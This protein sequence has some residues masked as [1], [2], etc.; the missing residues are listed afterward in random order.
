MSAWKIAVH[1][2]YKNGGT[3]NLR[4]LQMTLG[5]TDIS[6]GSL[7][8]AIRL[9]L[10]VLNGKHSVK[11][12]RPH[13]LFSLTT[14]GKLWCQ[15]KLIDGRGIGTARNGKALGF[16]ATWLLALP[17]GVHVTETR[18]FWQQPCI[19]CGSQRVLYYPDKPATMLCSPCVTASFTVLL[20]R[21]A[22]TVTKNTVSQPH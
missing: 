11:G 3:A 2:L 15:G 12:Q 6:D 5:G 21:S 20:Q 19:S 9:G 18:S 14:K 4:R 8:V 17:E 22:T 7:R 1:E 16:M 10:V 13:S